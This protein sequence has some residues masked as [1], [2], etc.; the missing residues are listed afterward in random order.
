MLQTHHVASDLWSNIRSLNE[1]RFLY[2]AR[3][4]NRAVNL[5]PLA[6][7]HEDFLVAQQGYL[8]GKQGKAD[9]TFWKEELGGALPT[10]QLQTDF[11]RPSMAT[12][13]GDFI[14]FPLDLRLTRGLEKLAREAGV[15][16][17]SVFLSAYQVLLHRYTGQ[18]DILVG[19]PTAGRDADYAQLFGYFVSPVVMRAQHFGMSFYDFLQKNDGNI[20]AVLTHANYPFPLVAEAL[21]YER[22]PGRPPVFQAQ[23]V[24]ENPNRFENRDEPLVSVDGKGRE[25]WDM[26]VGAWRR[27]QLKLTVD[28]Y[29]LTMKVVKNGGRY[30]GMLEYRPDLFA[31][32]TIQR[33]AANFTVL[34]RDIVKRPAM[35]I[36]ALATLDRKEKEQ[37][38]VGWNN[39]T[40]DNGAAALT[41][42]DLF[43]RQVARTPD[44]IAVIF[45]DKTLSYSQ[46]ATYARQLGNCL[47][48]QGIGPD[49]LVGVT[50]ERSL[51]MVIALYGI[52]YSGAAYVPIDPDLPVDRMAFMIEDTRISILLTQINLLEQIPE[53]NTEMI[54][55]DRDWDQ[56]SREPGDKPNVTVAPSHAAYMIYTSG[57]TGKPK[58][59]VIPHKSICNHFMW[60]QAAYSLDDADI[61]VLKTP[62][63]FDASVLAFFWPLQTGAKL[64]IAKPGGHKD[65]RYLAELIKEWH[66]TTIQLVPILLKALLDDKILP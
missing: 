64:L 25:I 58:G 55:L 51:E 22:D 2:E 52:L 24:Y 34:L 7:T 4:Q 65:S 18:D 56:I 47:R 35:P 54:C 20:S 57:S 9:A 10:L 21:T 49:Q 41:L 37:L 27:R 60:L 66:A 23:F 39:T 31:Q 11:P 62:Y 3:L 38:L 19:V 8:R 17:F 63:V 40:V 29:E 16:P 53:N 30:Y 13:K 46:L 6:K 28:P 48:T 12:C 33:M 26:H 61:L 1:V 45:Q 32:E 36:E 44:N 5:A 15:R 42:I 14:N 59:V 43:D 50:M